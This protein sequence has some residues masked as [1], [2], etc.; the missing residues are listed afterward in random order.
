[1]TFKLSQK[2]IEGLQSSNSIVTIDTDQTITGTKTFVNTINGE[3]LYAKWGDLA[4]IYSADGN[5]LPGTLLQFGGINEVTLAKTKANAVVST[6]PGLL[7]NSNDTV[8]Y[9]TAVALV[10][11]V[12]V[13]V[14]GTCQKFDKIELSDI[15][16]VA[17]K[18]SLQK[19]VIGVCLQNKP[20][21]EESLI[22]CAVRLTF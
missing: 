3:C 9:P 7:I 13:R 5:Y 14:I 21:E 19:E 15:P 8:E 22:L 10:G 11:K 1:M 4:E 20:E 18:S 16:G 2:A 6:K 17:I 12:P